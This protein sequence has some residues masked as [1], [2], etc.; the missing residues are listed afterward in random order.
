M[1]L[2]FTNYLLILIIFF[3]LLF[4]QFIL[5]VNILNIQIYLIIILCLFRIFLYYVDNNI[6]NM[7]E[8]KSN[9]VV[10]VI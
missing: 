1:I 6:W 8:L 3:V 4:I 10:D 9:D 7:Y 5:C 2:K